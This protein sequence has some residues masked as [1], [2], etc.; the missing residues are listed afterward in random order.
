MYCPRCGQ[1]Q[2]SDEMRF[3]SRCGL[4]MS[5]L[6]EWLAGGAVPV[7][8]AAETKAPARS[9]RRKGVRR[10]AKVM[11]L[12][13]VL[14][15]FFLA[16]SLAVDE[17]GPLIFPVLI[18]F[19]GL[20]MMLYSRLFVEDIPSIQ[21]QQ[22]QTSRFGA[23]SG[24]SALPPSSSIPIQGPGNFAGQ[25]VRTNELAQP[26]S[27]TEHTTKLLDQDPVCWIASRVPG[28]LRTRMALKT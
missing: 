26:P 11:F 9:P 10:G 1:Q 22:V 18:F 14:F 24:A 4:P 16:L 17:G 12:S 6:A 28:E 19:V 27:V 3:C 20:A 5:G 7:T 15:P 8:Q 2:I 25:Q 13:G 21:G 23:M